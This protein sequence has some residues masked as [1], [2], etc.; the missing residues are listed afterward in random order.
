MKAR[1]ERAMSEL[2][3]LFH[4]SAHHLPMVDDK[5][6]QC[7]TTSPPY[8][9]LRAYSGDQNIEWPTVTYAPMAGLPPLTVAGCDAECE[10]EWGAAAT[11]AI[12]NAPSAKS[13][14]TTNN[15]KGPQEGDKYHHAQKQTTTQ[16]AYCQKCGG[17]RGPLGNEPTLEAYIGHLILCA[18]EWRRVLRDDGVCFVNL[19]DSYATSPAGNK[20]ATGFQQ[21]QSAGKAGALAQWQ[22]GGATTRPQSVPNKNLLMV[23]ARFALAMQADG[24]IL[25]SE[26]VWAKPSPMPESVTDRPTK[27]H[28]MIYLFSKRERYFWDADAVRE[29]ASEVSLARIRQPNFENQ[30]G[31]PKDYANGINPN[32]S[33]RKTLENFALNPGRNLRTV[34]TIAT[35][36][37]SAAHFATWPPA[38]VEPMIKAGT[39]ARGCC[40]ECGTPWRRVVEQEPSNWQER[41]AKGAG[42]GSLVNGHNASHGV[43]TD[44]TL[45]KRQSVT[46]GWEAGC[47]CPPAEPVPCVVL[48]PFCGSGTTLKVAL[49]LGRKAWGCDI[50]A[51][52]L[53]DLAPQRMA[54]TIG[55]GI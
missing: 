24:W 10:H 44:H 22:E 49:E 18:R 17:W 45:G 6:V 37:Y 8:Y 38:L 48:D 5:S 25:R 46:V 36:P 16:C 34:L 28:E 50:S 26:M 40:P 54:V 4:A 2:A 53:D 9:G 43:G 13:T 42:S 47:A 32:R 39:S 1:Q 7:V 52:Y 31:G 3:K 15:G 51:E 21:K 27:A 30:T 35:Q 29:A 55:M 41:K 12:G 11:V 20:V 14:L 23:P 33:M 19:G